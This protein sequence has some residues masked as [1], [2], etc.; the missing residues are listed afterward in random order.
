MGVTITQSAMGVAAASKRR[1]VTPESAILRATGDR[2]AGT[3]VW[4]DAITP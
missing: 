1:L 3:V 2:D 4:P